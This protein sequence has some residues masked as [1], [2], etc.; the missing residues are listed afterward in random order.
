[1]APP[2]SLAE[3]NEANRQHNRQVIRKLV[4]FSFLM[5]SLPIAA[6]YVLNHV[7]RD[8]ENKTMWSGF[9][10]I[11]VVNVVIVA[12]IIEAFRED[13]AAAKDN[14]VPSPVVGKVKH[15]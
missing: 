11:G 9:G 13:A 2:T 4:F 8:S 10:A 1:M 3:R 15:S 7:F 14:A 5:F 12:Y 6:F